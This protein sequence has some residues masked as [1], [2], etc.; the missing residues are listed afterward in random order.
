M[1]S[2]N[3]SL[4]VIETI[5]E[6]WAKTDG[7]KAIVWQV[8]GVIVLI[9]ILQFIAGIILGIISAITHI[10]I[11]STMGNVMLYAVVI[12]FGVVTFLAMMSQYYIGIQKAM[13]LPI[14][15]NMVKYPFKIRMTINL[16]GFIL[17]F[18]VIACVL[19]FPLWFAHYLYVNQAS[20]EHINLIKLAIASLDIIGFFCLLYYIYL[21][22]GLYLSAGMIIK[23]NM[24]PWKAFKT[25]LRAIKSN[26][27]RLVAMLFLNCII[28]VLGAIPLGIG[29]IW[30][31]PYL[32]VNYGVIYNK[33]Y[34]S[35]R[36]MLE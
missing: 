30:V 10:P 24:T 35:R 32:F 20:Y 2:D 13:G 4:P 16:I 8:M 7:A 29:L 12:P 25:S 26:R 23:E 27:C 22:I 11:E 14:Q 33:L 6:S 28:L 17:L 3:Y 1:P 15:F 5:K 34:A 21:F 18:A 9:Y 19:R 31:L 36:A